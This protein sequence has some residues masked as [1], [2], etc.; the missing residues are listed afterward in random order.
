MVFEHD[1]AGNFQPH[2]RA[3]TDFFGGKKRIENLV[4][5]RFRNPW[6]VVDDVNH[7]LFV[8]HISAHL[9][10]A[11]FGG[12]IHGIVDQIGPNLVHFAGMNTHH[13]HV[14][15]KFLDDLDAFF[16][17]LVL[18][19]D[20]GAANAFVQIGRLHVLALVHVG[21]GLDRVDQSANA[22][23]RLA[24]FLHQALQAQGAFNPPHHRIEFFAVER[25]LHG[26]HIFQAQ[27]KIE[28][29]FGD[30]VGIVDVMVFQ[31]VQNIVLAGLA[32]QQSQFFDWALLGFAEQNCI[33]CI[34]FFGGDPHGD[35]RF[36]PLRRLVDF[37]VQ[38]IRAAHQGGGGVVEFMRQSSRQFAQRHQFFILQALFGKG[39]DPARHDP[40]QV[41]GQL[42][43][44]C[45]HFCKTGT[46]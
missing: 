15:R 34:G 37:V 46:G 36:E 31:P 8:F 26:F 13:R 16:L 18:E 21:V 5:D 28:K 40:N 9:E 1:A 14:F 10:H 11:S 35:H 39:F 6:A 22:V 23:G 30:I 43:T 29:G 33:E 3:F 32:L 12:G 17:K 2:T 45:Y 25:F 27:A 7:R 20:H 42:I 38:L 19:H 44:D 4:A 41:L 24:D